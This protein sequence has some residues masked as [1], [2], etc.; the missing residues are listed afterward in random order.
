MTDTRNPNPHAD[1]RSMYETMVAA[2]GDPN[3]VA[4]A[5]EFLPTYSSDW[6]RFTGGGISWWPEYQY[7]YNPQVDANDIAMRT[8]AYYETVI[9]DLRDRNEDL[10]SRLAGTERH[11]ESLS[12]SLRDQETLARYWLDKLNDTDAKLATCQEDRHIA[13]RRL[14]NLQES[15]DDLDESLI[16]ANTKL[17]TLL[18]TVK[19]I[20]EDD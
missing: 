17:E 19:N 2:G 3:K 8:P 10:R 7:R 5:F 4:R 13:E 20:V 18:E 12:A 9:K 15:Y 14:E 1:L 16:N 6:I 11:A